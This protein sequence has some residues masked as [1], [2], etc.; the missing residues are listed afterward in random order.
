MLCIVP[1]KYV[2]HS[3]WEICCGLSAVWDKNRFIDLKIWIPPMMMTFKKTFL[4]L[5]FGIFIFLVFRGKS[6]NTNYMKETELL[7]QTQVFESLLCRLMWWKPLIFQLNIFDLSEFTVWNITGI[8]HR[9][10]KI[11]F[12]PDFYTEGLPQT[13][14]CKPLIFQT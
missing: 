3:S 13:W 4:F 5:I 6:A 2:V 11:L 7:P 9:V 8:R 12:T 14:W 10:A 1:E